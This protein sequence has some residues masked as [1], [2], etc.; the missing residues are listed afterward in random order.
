MVSLDASLV[1]RS[2]SVG[3]GGVEGVSRDEMSRTVCVSASRLLLFL[4]SGEH[5]G[6]E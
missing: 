2:W 5:G 6:P 1:P 4:P 3:G